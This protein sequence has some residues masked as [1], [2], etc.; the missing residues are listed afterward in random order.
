MTRI[1]VAVALA[2]LIVVPSAFAGPSATAAD[3]ARAVS[4]CETLRPA[5]NGTVGAGTFG[6]AFGTARAARADAF[7]NCVRVFTVEVHQNRH[8]VVAACEEST[9]TRREFAECVAD[10]MRAASREDRRDWVN[11]AETCKAERETNAE[12]FATAYGEGRNAY[13]MCVSTHAKAQNDEEPAG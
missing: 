7:R 11:A 12:A 8:A 13:G 1:G 3:R 9:T 2:A 6:K 10:G 4:D 5:M